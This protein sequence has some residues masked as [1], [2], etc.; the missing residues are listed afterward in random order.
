MDSMIVNPIGT[1]RVSENGFQIELFP[2]YRAGLAGL[3]GFGH[4]MVTWWLSGCGDPASRALLSEE[5]PYAKGPQRLGV[6]A[7]RSPRRPNPIALSC[8]GIT[9]LDEDNGIVYCDYLDAADGSPVL[10]LKPYTPSL[11][12]V[13]RPTVPAWCAHWPESVELSGDFDWEREISF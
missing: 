5:H 1:V 3:T 9:G 12:R 6:F 11:D 10:D 4:L 7:T 8:A 13:E 2:A